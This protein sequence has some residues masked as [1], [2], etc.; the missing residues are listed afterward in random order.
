MPVSRSLFLPRLPLVL[1]FS[2]CDRSKLLCW[3]HD[4]PCRDRSEGGRLHHL[5]MPQRGLVETGAVL[6]AGVPQRPIVV[7]ET[8]PPETTEAKL[9]RRTYLLHHFQKKEMIDSIGAQFPKQRLKLL[10][11]PRCALAKF[12]IPT[13]QAAEKEDGTLFLRFFSPA[14]LAVLYIFQSNCCAQ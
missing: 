2:P 7:I 3:N 8:T 5:P 4:H 11:Q 12:C 6:A 1:P 13:N 10:R 14:K 9:G